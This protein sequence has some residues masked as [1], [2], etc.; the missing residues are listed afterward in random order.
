MKSAY[1]VAR[2]LLKKVDWVESSSG[3]GGSRVWAT[4]W[5]LQIP[6][7]IKVFGWRVCLEGTSRR[8]RFY[9]MI[10]VRY[11]LYSRNKLFMLYGNA[12]LRRMFGLV[13]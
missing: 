11:V 10:Y 6:N 1:K 5:K 12:Q 9:W 3:S 13:V 7:K 2:A 4:I 8:N